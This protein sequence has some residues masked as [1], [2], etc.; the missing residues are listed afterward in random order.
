MPMMPQHEYWQLRIDK[1]HANNRTR[2]LPFDMGQKVLLSTKNLCG[3]KSALTRKSLFHFIRPFHVLAK[4][5]KQAYELELTPILKMHGVF[6]VSLLGPSHEDEL[7]DHQPPPLRL[8]VDG[9]QE[10]EVEL[11]RQ[12]WIINPSFQVTTSGSLRLTV[13]WAWFGP[14]H[15]TWDPEAAIQSCPAIVQTYRR[16][17][18]K[19]PL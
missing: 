17:Q 14:Q 4:L 15:D 18:K 7:H 12:S 10:H 16:Q 13:R 8:L 6:H 5:G 1:H 19:P 9:E 3:K 11:L 2:Q